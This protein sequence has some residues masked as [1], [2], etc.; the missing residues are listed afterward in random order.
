MES[1][2]GV[3]ILIVIVALLAL[4]FFMAQRSRNKVERLRRTGVYPRAGEETEADVD[5]LILK[6]HKI[7]AI[8]VFRA[9]H[10]VDLKEAKDAVEQRQRELGQR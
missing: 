2:L 6:G 1:Q 8:K 3:Q 4:G 5:R 9:L 10:G 7:E